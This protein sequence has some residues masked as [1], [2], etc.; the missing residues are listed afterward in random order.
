M[1]VETNATADDSSQG[2]IRQE[3]IEKIMKAAEKVFAGNGFRGATT[4]AIAEE[5]GLPK[6][7]IH[8]YFGTKAKLYRAVLDDIIALWLSSFRE[9]GEND[10]PATT[11]AD[12]IRAKMQLSQNRPNASKVFANELIRGAPRISGYLE[13]ELKE[14]VEEKAAILD[15]WIEEG[16]MA[17]VDSKRLLFHIW[18]MTQTWADFEVQWAAVLGRK[19]KLKAEDFDAATDF[20]ITIVLRTC[21]LQPIPSRS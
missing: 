11:L 2:R 5:A 10:D 9:I 14:W 4:A 13:T 3:N 7:N 1:N 17:P 6:A 18:S 21:G 12:Y 20:I 15:H 16:R 19:K 8:Y